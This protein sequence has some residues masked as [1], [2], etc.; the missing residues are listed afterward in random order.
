MTNQDAIIGVIGTVIGGIIT[1]IVSWQYYKKAGDELLKESKKLKNTSDLILYKIQYPD[2]QT[3][4]VRDEKGEVQ[5]LKV[6]MSANNKMQFEGKGN[7]TTN[8][9]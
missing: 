1:W 4:L 6:N 9:Q 5:S 2:A 7:L 3:E 8:N